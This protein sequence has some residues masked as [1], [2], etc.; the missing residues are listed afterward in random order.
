MNAYLCET[1]YD[2]YTPGTGT[3]VVIIAP[4]LLDAVNGYYK[5]NQRKCLKSVSVIAEDVIILNDTRLPL[6]EIKNHLA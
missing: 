2:N 5:E 1:S 3:Q 4:T 6:P